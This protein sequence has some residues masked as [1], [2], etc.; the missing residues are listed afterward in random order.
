MN[1]SELANELKHYL[2]LGTTNEEFVLRL[3]GDVIRQ[4]ASDYEDR[5]ALTGN[6]NPVQN[7]AE[8]TRRKYFNGSLSIPKT[9]AREIFDRYDGSLLTEMIDDLETQQKEQLD[10]FLRNKGIVVELDDL[11]SAVSDILLQIIEGCVKGNGEVEVCARIY[12]PKAR[13]DS[14]AGNRVYYD[15]RNGQIV[16]D[17]DVVELPIRLSQGDIDESSSRFVDALCSAYADA[18]S[19]IVGISDTPSLP[20]KYRENYS[21]QIEAY[22]SAESIQRSIRD[23]YADG[24]N[25]FDILKQDAYYAIRVAYKD[26]YPNGY[27]R[28]V[29]VLKLA[30]IA[31]L[32]KSKL[33]V[34]KNLI[35]SLEKQGLMH[36]LVE[37]GTMPSWVDPYG[38]DSNEP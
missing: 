18:L 2:F 20:L 24:E 25:Q 16:I 34:I 28:L 37:D 9:R 23:V 38:D 13:I 17:G 12:E 19:R 7:V 3:V 6:L 1:F 30:A 27:K 36:I 8:D 14:L 29:E 33:M 15:D 22:L 21:D 35:G 5:K 10:R 11:G 31:P 32:E 26:D 4:P